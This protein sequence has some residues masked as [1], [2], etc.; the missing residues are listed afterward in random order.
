MSDHSTNPSTE[1]DHVNNQSDPSNPKPLVSSVI[2][3]NINSHT[4]SFNTQL[5]T[6]DEA[7]NP[8]AR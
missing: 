8:N 1:S 4:V 2:Q 3:E 7:F 6:D 5:L